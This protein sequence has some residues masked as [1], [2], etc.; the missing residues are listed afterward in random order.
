MSLSR[1]QMMERSLTAGAGLAAAYA[2]VPSFVR[3]AHAQETFGEVVDTQ[4]FARLEKVADGVWAVVSTPFK[5]GAF[6]TVCNGGI[7]VG[8][9]RILAV[10]AYLR[11]SGAAWLSAQ[12]EAL[13]GR[14]PTDVIVTHVHADHTG[15]LAGF[16]NG[17]E[18]PEI[19][20]TQQTY[21]ILIERYSAPQE[22]EKTPR[23][24]RP[25]VRLLA[26]TGIISGTEDFTLDLGGR[27]A[28]LSFTS[29]H[30]DSDV[31][32]TVD[33]PKVVFAGDLLWEGIFPNFVDAQPSALM[34]NVRS[35]LKL[36]NT[37]LVPG[38]GS[39]TRPDGL[40]NYLG[41]LEAIEAAARQAHADGVSAEEAAKAFTLPASLGEWQFFS[42]RYFEVA[43]GAWLKEL[44]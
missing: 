41:V 4:P 10:D 19:L 3:Q 29:G 7:I 6:D 23:I 38:H 15:G 27:T 13:T 31:T 26:P 8:K 12:C 28:T 25:R 18:G 43:I 21:E 1:R 35:L 39:V 24:G 44:G 32:V 5:A 33:D 17:A 22:D 2:W 30:T 37:I 40:T 9:E 11:P 16:Q 14:R 36:E 20:A 34:A 42:P